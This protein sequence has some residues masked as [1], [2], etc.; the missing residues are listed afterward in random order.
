MNGTKHLTDS[1]EREIEFPLIQVKPSF[2]TNL[3][4]SLTLHHTRQ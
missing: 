1:L 2:Y 4:D 3:P